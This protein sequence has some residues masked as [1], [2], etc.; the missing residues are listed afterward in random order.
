MFVRATGRSSNCSVLII[1]MNS[2]YLC[3]VYNRKLVNCI[4]SDTTTYIS[5]FS[6]R[7]GLICLAT[8][9]QGSISFN[10]QQSHFIHQAKCFY[11]LL[12]LQGL[13][14]YRSL[15]TWVVVMPSAVICKGIVSG[16]FTINLM[17]KHCNCI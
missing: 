14:A 13:V 7:M 10:V 12:R 3:K 5:L 16:L 8:L 6:F 9:S 15:G 4:P 11:F 17:Q 2:I 1:D